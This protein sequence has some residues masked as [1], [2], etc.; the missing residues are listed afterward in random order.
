MSTCNLKHI[1]AVL[2][3]PVWRLVHLAEALGIEPHDLLRGENEKPPKRGPPPKLQRQMERISGLPK[4]QQRSIM[5]VLDMALK[6][7]A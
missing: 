2:V 6:A 1:N 7:G 5:Q 3:Q 4:E